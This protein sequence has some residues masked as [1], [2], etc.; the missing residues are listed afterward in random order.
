LNCNSAPGGCAG[1]GSMAQ[2]GERYDRFVFTA[3]RM[4]RIRSALSI[5]L[6]GLESEGK[7][8]RSAREKLD[9][10]LNHDCDGLILDVRRARLR[11]DEVSPA[12]RNVRASLL[13]RVLVVTG[14]VTEPQVLQQIEALGALHFPL[15]HMTTGLRPFAPAFS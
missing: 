8:T 15:K 9:R 5:L 6:A 13:G 7:V 3:D 2:Q 14:E 4:P 10:V 1:R 11:P 12:V